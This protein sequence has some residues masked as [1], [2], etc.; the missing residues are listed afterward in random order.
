VATEPS[1]RVRANLALTISDSN[2]FTSF[3]R[4]RHLLYT[5]RHLS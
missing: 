4:V 5:R 1:S 3:E 2:A